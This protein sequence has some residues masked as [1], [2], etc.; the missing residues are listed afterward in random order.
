MTECTWV[1]VLNG[2]HFPQKLSP[3]YHNAVL[4][5]GKDKLQKL[6]GYLI[7]VSFPYWKDGTEWSH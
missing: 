5:V 2:I 4:C 6:E 7:W 3:S 1:C